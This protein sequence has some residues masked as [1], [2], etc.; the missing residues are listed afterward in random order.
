MPL[1]PL[2]PFASVLA[3]ALLLAA[4]ADLP[5]QSTGTFPPPG[6]PTT[7]VMKT[8]QQIEP[9][10]D[11]LNSIGANGVTTDATHHFIITSPGSYYLTAN[12]A[13]TKTSGIQ[14]TADGVTLDLN[15]FALTRGSGTVGNAIELAANVDR[16]TIVNGSISGFSFGVNAIAASPYPRG[17]TMRA[18]RVANCTAVGLAGGESSLLIDCTAQ[19]CG[20][21]L[22]GQNHS[23]FER[24]TSSTSKGTYAIFA[25]S[26]ATLTHCTVTRHTT[27]AVNGAAF[28][29]GAGSTLSHCAASAN[30]CDRG[31][32][33]GSGAT[34]SDCSATSSTV[35]FGIEV[36][37][38][39]SL[40]RC[41]ANSNTSTAATSG[42]ILAGANASITQCAANA[43]NSTA[44][45][46]TT[47]TGL[48]FSVSG[49]GTMQG[50]TASNNKGDGI[51]ATFTAIRQCTAN[52]NNQFGIFANQ[53]CSVLGCMV[54][55]NKQSGIRGD[56]VGSIIDCVC[57]FNSVCGI[58]I[59]SNGGFDVRGN[60]C[61]ENGKD[62]VAQGAGIRVNGGFTRVDGNH[63][64]VNYRGIDVNV[65]GVFVVRNAA[66]AN[67]SGI[68]F[69]IV[70]GNKV[71]TIVSAPASGAINGNT[72]GAGVG[73]T[74]PWANVSY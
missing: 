4:R 38:G 26:N 55:T 12:L 35:V 46:L 66:A 58:L 13:V 62:A 41:T 68:N 8:L 53:R 5:A 69:A 34:L 73:S 9:R 65:V 43:N 32:L 40:A 14:I 11:L 70:S 59:D 36:G 16:T 72:G 31:I 64:Y 54:T 57:S 24:C 42:G 37:G 56:L 29:A 18:L 7:P 28:F 49:G 47:T 48:G 15:G 6:V 20:V 21:S 45:T 22:S 51:D 50:C 25:E 23:T 71:G 19:D 1:V 10:V 60:T 2:R 30:T 67:T 17:T 74:D 61:E 33:T 52:A 27:A 44:G 63:V 3:C 39:S